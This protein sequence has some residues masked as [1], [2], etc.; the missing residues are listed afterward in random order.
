MKA[1]PVWRLFTLES[2]TQKV[3]GAED[4]WNSCDSARTAGRRSPP[5]P[6]R[7]RSQL[8]AHPTELLTRAERGLLDKFESSALAPGHLGR[9]DRPDTS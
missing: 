8:E 1:V 5:Q 2:A 7:P 9:L 3:R 4:G 6:S